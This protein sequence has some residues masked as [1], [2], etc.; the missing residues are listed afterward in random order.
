MNSRNREGGE[1]GGE[2]EGEGEE[3]GRKKNDIADWDRALGRRKEKSNKSEL[4]VEKKVR[5]K[6]SAQT[7]GEK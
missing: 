5:E 3:L 6:K 4:G 7:V 1:E 2:E